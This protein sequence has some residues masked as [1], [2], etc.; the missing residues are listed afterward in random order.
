MVEQ[1]TAVRH[2]RSYCRPTPFP[3][4]FA[5]EDVAKSAEVME[6]QCAGC[7][8]WGGIILCL[9]GGDKGG[10]RESVDKAST[11]SRSSPENPRSP[12]PTPPLKNRGGGRIQEGAWG[13][14]PRPFLKYHTLAPLVR[15]ERQSPTE[16]RGGRVRGLCE[17][18]GVGRVSTHSRSLGNH[19]ESTRNRAACRNG[20]PRGGRA[21]PSLSLEAH[22]T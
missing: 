8:L 1:A 18:G 14:A 16:E 12:T 2:V 19:L 11:L 17:S 21:L 15:G 20:G 13:E 4:R 22:H 3:G 9:S 7:D 6:R 10:P 5:M